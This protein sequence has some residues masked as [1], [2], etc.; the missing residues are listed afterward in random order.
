MPPTATATGLSTRRSSTLATARVHEVAKSL[1]ILSVNLRT[2]IPSTGKAHPCTLLLHRCTG[3]PNTPAARRPQALQSSMSARSPPPAPPRA[4]PPMFA[5]EADSESSD[6]D[7]D[8]SSSQ[9]MDPNVEISIAQEKKSI[10]AEQ[11]RLQ[12][13][14][15]RR[16]RKPPFSCCRPAVLA[17]NSAGALRFAARRVLCTHTNHPYFS[18]TAL[19][20]S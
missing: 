8:G 12:V 2:G 13:C 10:M 6:S 5:D 17:R 3:R 1:G 18:T 19:G 16:P 4:P 9:M 11:K 14:Y 7:D 20:E 15:R